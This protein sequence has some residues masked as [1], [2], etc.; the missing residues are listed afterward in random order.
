MSLIAND[1]SATEQVTISLRPE[2]LK[3][4]TYEIVQQLIQEI[5]NISNL[6]ITLVIVPGKRATQMLRN[7]QIH[8]ELLRIES[9]PKIVAEAIIIPAS[10]IT[11]TI[12]AYSASLDFKISGWKSLEPYSIINI[13]GYIYPTEKL[14]N[15]KFIGADSVIQAFQLLNANRADIFTINESAAHIVLQHPQ[16]KHS[17]IK[18]LTPALEKIKFYTFFS[19]KYPDIAAQ[20]NT[21]LLTLKKQGK[22]AKIL[23]GNR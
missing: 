18:Q 10:K 8:A 12:H 23:T 16:F 17:K 21:A 13:R 19:A 9:Y 20:Y 3:G 22:L 2:N 7:H 14:P 4:K 6:N 1:L 5:E 11:A 15:K